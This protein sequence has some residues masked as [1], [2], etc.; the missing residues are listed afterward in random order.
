MDWLTV[1]VNSH[2]FHVYCIAY[3]C[4]FHLAPLLGHPWPLISRYRRTYIVAIG[5]AIANTSAIYFLHKYINIYNCIHIA[6]YV[7]AVLYYFK[8]AGAN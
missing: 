2:Q 4:Q 7:I 8:G 1:L 5:M 6:F 3:V